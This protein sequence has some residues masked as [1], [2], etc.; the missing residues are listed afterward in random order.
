[1]CP[2][3][4]LGGDGATHLALSRM[5]SGAFH[6]GSCPWEVSADLNVRKHECDRDE[7]KEHILGILVLSQYP[8]FFNTFLSLL[9]I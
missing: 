7:A 3:G 1:M 5:Y 9:R 8:S 4:A 2:L 6:Q